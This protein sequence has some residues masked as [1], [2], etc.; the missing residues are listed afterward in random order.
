MVLAKCRFTS[1]T[2]VKMGVMVAFIHT[3]LRPSN[4]KQWTGCRLDDLMVGRTC[5]GV[6]FWRPQLP[7]LFTEQSGTTWRQFASRNDR[8]RNWNVMRKTSVYSTRHHGRRLSMWLHPLWV[9]CAY[10]PLLYFSIFVW[11]TGF[12]AVSGFAHG[13]LSRATILINYWVITC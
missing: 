13:K 8:Y 2:A 7:M 9:H 11:W 1:K 5:C 3:V 6:G 10:N 12:D 4:N